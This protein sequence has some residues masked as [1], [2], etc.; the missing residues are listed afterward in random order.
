MELNWK[1][2]FISSSI[3]YIDPLSTPLFDGMEKVKEML[4]FMFDGI[5]ENAQ[6]LTS[7][8]YIRIRK[9]LS[10]MTE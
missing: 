9:F 6:S 4:F 1:I 5:T 8:K 2:K 7:N 3:R 10:V